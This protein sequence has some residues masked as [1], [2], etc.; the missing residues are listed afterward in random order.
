[1]LPIQDLRMDPDQRVEVGEYIVNLFYVS[2]ILNLTMIVG[3][4][5]IDTFRSIRRSYATKS[6]ICS[7]RKWKRHDRHQTVKID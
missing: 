6:G 5:A 1:M 4:V 3:R 7:C 2:A